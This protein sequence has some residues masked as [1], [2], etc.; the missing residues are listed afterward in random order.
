MIT[1]VNKEG[2]TLKSK[3]SRTVPL[4]SNLKAILEPL[5]RNKG[6]CF[7]DAD[8]NQW[9][10]VRLSDEFKR[11]IVK[12]SG[13]ANFSLHTLR[14]TFASHLVMKGVSIYKVSTWLG[15]STVSTTMIYAHLAPQDN[16]IDKL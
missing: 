10:P 2:F 8:G 6:F 5:A 16:E 1:L 15:H 3:E 13:L 4:N 14:H 11:L 7:R 9:T 12:P